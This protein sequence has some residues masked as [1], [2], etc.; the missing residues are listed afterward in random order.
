MEKFYRHLREGMSEAE[1]LRAAQIIASQKYAHPCHWVAFGVTRD[2]GVD[3]AEV[4]AE[5]MPTPTA[6]T[7]ERLGRR[8]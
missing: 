4:A 6:E 2:P 3:K 8:I 1:A 7:G 5:A